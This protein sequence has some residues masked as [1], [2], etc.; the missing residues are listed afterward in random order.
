MQYTEFQLDNVNFLKE[1]YNTINGS[2]YFSPY[3]FM[4]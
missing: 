3:I 1:L 4:L 2:R